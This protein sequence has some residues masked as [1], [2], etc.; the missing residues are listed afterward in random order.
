VSPCVADL[1]LAVSIHTQ[2]SLTA[3]RAASPTGEFG[4]GM[5]SAHGISKLGAM[6]PLSRANC[7]RQMGRKSVSDTTAKTSAAKA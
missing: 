3:Q 6:Y 1:K 4:G 2:P 5:Y 7:S